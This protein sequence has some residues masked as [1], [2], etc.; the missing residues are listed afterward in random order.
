MP[1]CKPTS[2]PQTPR[3]QRQR[4]RDIIRDERIHPI[5]GLPLSVQEVKDLL[6]EFPAIN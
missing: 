5:T 6:I 3:E 1:S 2:K 4:L